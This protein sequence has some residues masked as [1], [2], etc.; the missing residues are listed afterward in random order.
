MPGTASPNLTPATIPATRI[1]IIVAVAHLIN[2]AY[3]SVVPPLLPRI[4]NDLDLS[5]AAAATLGASFAIA[6]AIPQPF[7]G[8]LADRFGRRIFAVGGVVTSAVFV[9]LIGFAPSFWP[10]L[11]MLVMGGL[12]G[13]AF[14]P[15]GASYAV[16]VGAGRGGG[17]RY[18]VFSFG[19]AVG[20]AAGPLVAVA[21]VAWGGMKG[22]WVAMLPAVLFAPVLYRGLPSGR[23]E[24]RGATPPPTP[25][26]VLRRLA[27]PLGIIFGIS[28]TMAFVQRVFLTM[29]PIIVADMG[30]SE[31]LGA[32]ALSVYLG[33]QAF[34]TL[35]G[36]FLTDRVSR[37]RLLFHLCAWALPAHLLA[38]WLGPWTMTGMLA[39]AAAG[40]LGMATLPPIVVMAQEMYPRA[41]GASSGIV[42]G[43][44]WAVGALGVM[45]TGAVADVTGPQ[46]AAL[47][48]LPV[49]G[50]AAL[51]A[52][53][54]GLKYDDPGA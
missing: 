17:K 16:R 6:T 1:A 48:S 4:M 46:A 42:M 33:A 32:A 39:I 19:G 3:A 14:H 53:H 11:L 40:F 27:G 51:L 12:G 5:I 22:L 9:S 23:R 43:L 7:F 38:V 15:P 13:A 44:A 25:A 2:D 41:A 36:G 31:T 18:S 47:M 50:L 10:L 29:E 54:P 20:Y 37:P 26:A 52:L 8:Y 35:T 34:G 24:T 21:L 49:A 28:A 45:V 30:G